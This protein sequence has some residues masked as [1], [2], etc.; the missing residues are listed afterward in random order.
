MKF[1]LE[2]GPSL[3]ALRHVAPS[4]HSQYKLGEATPALAPGASVSQEIS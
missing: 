1:N 3:R 4:S 2:V